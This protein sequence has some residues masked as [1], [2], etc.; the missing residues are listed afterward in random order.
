[1]DDCIFCKIINKEIP[2]EYILDR[3]NFIVIKDI[4][5]K[6]PIH[7]LFIPKKHIKS[8]LHLDMDDSKLLSD[9]MLGTKEIANNLG[10][11]EK[12]YKLVVNTGKDCGQEVMHLHIHFLADL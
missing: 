1:M 2:T 4:V 10:L 7:Y 11:N 9:M 5:P 6:A 8:M 3:D 12:G